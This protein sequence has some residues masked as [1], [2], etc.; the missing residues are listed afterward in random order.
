MQRGYLRRIRSR[1]KP[2]SEKTWQSL[3][4]API[5]LI[6]S[7]SSLPLTTFPHHCPMTREPFPR[8]SVLK[9]MPTKLSNTIFASLIL[10]F[11]HLPWPK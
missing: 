11:L 1:S 8:A 5:I 9:D 4:I 2:V 6:S 3:M 10:R 7:H